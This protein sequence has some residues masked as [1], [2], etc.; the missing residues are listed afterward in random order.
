MNQYDP[1]ELSTFEIQELMEYLDEEE[2]EILFYI[3]SEP[4]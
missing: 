2:A 4:V 3:G 1:D